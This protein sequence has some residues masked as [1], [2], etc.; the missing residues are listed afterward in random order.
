MRLYGVIV[1]QRPMHPP[2]AQSFCISCKLRLSTPAKKPASYCENHT[3]VPIAF[4]LQTF[5]DEMQISLNDATLGTRHKQATST[6]RHIHRRTGMSLKRV[7]YHHQGKN[8]SVGK[9]HGNSRTIRPSTQ[10]CRIIRDIT[11]LIY[12]TLHAEM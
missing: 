4:I 8:E 12:Y 2:H 1:L 7:E 3:M 6:Q 10:W 5:P 9:K 11:Q